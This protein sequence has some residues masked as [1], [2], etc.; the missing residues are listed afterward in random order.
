MLKK[1]KLNIEC[2]GNK[3]KKYYKRDLTGLP[4]KII[5]LPEAKRAKGKKYRKEGYRVS[6]RMYDA[7]ELDWSL[8]V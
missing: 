5:K 4:K 6:T 7:L 2:I 3:T 8:G 1:L